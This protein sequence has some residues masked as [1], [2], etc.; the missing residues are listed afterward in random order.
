MEIIF[1]L[2]FMLSTA[3][4]T[5]TTKKDIKKQTIELSTVKR[6]LTPEAV[7]VVMDLT[8]QNNLN[9]FIKIV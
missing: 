9:L 4:G 5:V 3:F 8:T 6:V 1:S 2:L 7:L